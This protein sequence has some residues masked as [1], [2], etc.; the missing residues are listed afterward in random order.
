MR[1]ALFLTALL[2]ATPALAQSAPDADAEPVVEGGGFTQV[3]LFV[4]THCPHCAAAWEQLVPEV[5]ARHVPLHLHVFPLAAGCNPT[6]PPRDS[7]TR[8]AAARCLGARATVCAADTSAERE[9]FSAILD[10]VHVQRQPLTREWLDEIAPPLL[11]QEANL[12]RICMDNESHT[13]VDEDSRLGA[14]LGVQG[15]PSVFIDVIDQ[16][17]VEVDRWDRLPEVLDGEPATSETFEPYVPELELIL[18]A[19]RKVKAGKRIKPKQVQAIQAPA[20]FFPDFI[21]RGP[22]L[23]DL[24]ATTTILPGQPLHEARVTLQGSAADTADVPVRAFGDVGQAQRTVVIVAADLPAGRVLTADTVLPIPM[25]TE[26]ADLLGCTAE[27]VCPD[28][29]EGVVGEVLAAP[30]FR[31][32]ALRPE[33]IQ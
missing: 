2:V 16:P 24:R 25:R 7:A 22:G 13:R 8:D 33:M 31:S 17:W 3:H 18:V 21:L 4:D 11:G 9:V 10:R 32:E 1:T 19:T 15:V 12:F 20:G 26:L 30:V 28:A 23:P 5:D 27:A 6:V 29:L 14:D